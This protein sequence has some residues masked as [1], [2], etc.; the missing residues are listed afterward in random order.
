MSLVLNHTPVEYSSAHSDILFTVF[1]NDPPT[2]AQDNFKYLC[3]VYIGGVMIARL[4]AFPR[5]GTGIGVF[6]IGQI[7]RSYL[8]MEFTPDN[9]ALLTDAFGV[10][11][12]FQAVQCKFGQEYGFTTFTNLLTDTVRNYYN[13][14]TGRRT[15]GTALLA[16]YVDKRAST[17]PARL[18]TMS[19]NPFLFLPYFNVT[20]VSLEINIKA[21]SVTD[22]FDYDFDVDLDNE[23]IN[24]THFQV[25]SPLSL[26]QFNLAPYVIEGIIGT[27]LGNRWRYVLTINGVEFADVSIECEAIFTPHTLHFLNQFGGFESF[28]FRKLSRKTYDLEKK[29]YTQQPYRIGTGVTYNTN[30]VVHHTK[31]V[32]SSH[33]TEKLKVTSDLVSDEEYRWLRQLVVSP[34]VYLQEGDK[35]IPVTIISN[36]YEEK[37]VRNDKLT[38]LVLDLDFGQTLNAQY[39]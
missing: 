34:I 24:F 2:L 17:A 4:K 33:Y 30:G 6:N 16:S 8:A 20:D 27:T 35:L 19:S 26:C 13:Y 7:V 31:T 10:G 11:N 22:S 21:Y 15:D 29:D 18:Y 9:N 1:Q 12:F 38:S 14:Y 32:Y 23:D 3:D 37:Q 39:Q 25:V 5:P 28:D 36:N